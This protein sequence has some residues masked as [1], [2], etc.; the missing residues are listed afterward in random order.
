MTR[1]LVVEDNAENLDMLLRRLV[2]RGYDVVSADDGANAIAAARREHPDVILMDLGL[3]DING[4]EATRRLKS[5][6]LTRA[7]PVIA[8]T[9]HAM[10]GDR[11][12]ALAAGCDEYDTK[13][14][15]MAQLI[16]KIDSFVK[17]QA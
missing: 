9:A 2:R 8:L 7:I 11:D 3:P 10:R 14:V 6:A 13:P 1:I 12:A 17:E 5:D 16:A 15:E 4:L